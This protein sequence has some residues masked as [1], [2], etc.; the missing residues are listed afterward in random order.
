MVWENC[1]AT[2]KNELPSGAFNTWIKPLQASVQNNSLQLAAP[3]AAYIQEIQRNYYQRIMSLVKNHSQGQISKVVLIEHT[4]LTE[5][6]KLTP[7]QPQTTV[8]NAATIRATTLFAGNPLNPK[9]TFELFVKGRSNQMAYEACHEVLKEIGKSAHNPLF[10]YGATGLGKTHL[11]HAVGH[12]LSVHNKN[13]RYMTSDNFISQYVG[14]ARN[15]QV[16]DFIG[17]C[18]ASD[19]LMIDDIHLLTKNKSSSTVFENI[20]NELISHNKQIIL[21]SDKHPVQLKD[22]DEKLK[23]RFAWGLSIALEPPELETRVSIL[24]KKAQ[25]A[26]MVLP[27]ECALFIAQHVVANVRELEGALNK[28]FAFARFKHTSISLEVVQQALQEIVA[29]RAQIVSVDNIQ[30]IV[31][32]YY[33]LTVK[34]LTSAKRSRAIARPRQL[35]MSLS[36]ELTGDSYPDIGRAFGGRDHSTVMHACTKAQELRKTDPLFNRDYQH[37]LT[38]M[39]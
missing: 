26:D 25:V 5:T 33:G 22:I 37:I 27:K 2:L 20:F 31:A 17:Q 7:Q 6:F 23:S 34:D 24:H 3:N 13:V 21:A 29:I 1:L 36:R 11:M 38:M 12:A 9:F 15:K 14:A 4:Q 39:Q 32:E 10:L 8:D 28:V 35:A 18:R 19:L 30:K 16:D